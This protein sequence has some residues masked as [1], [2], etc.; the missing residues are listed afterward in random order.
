MAL[1]NIPETLNKIDQGFDLIEVCSFIQHDPIGPNDLLPLKNGIK[2]N[3]FDHADSG[4]CLQVYG[5]GLT[6]PQIDNL[7]NNQ[8]SENGKKPDAIKIYIGYNAMDKRLAA[9][10]VAAFNETTGVVDFKISRAQTIQ[11]IVDAN[12]KIEGTRPC[13]DNCSK[14]ILSQKI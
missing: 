10:A 12:I 2:Q 4:P 3:L 11:D 13:P 1:Q 7:L 9:Y 8:G 6:Q 5:F 14:N